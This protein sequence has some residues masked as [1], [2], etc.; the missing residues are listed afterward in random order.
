MQVRLL[1][2]AQADVRAEKIF[3]RAIE[4]ELAHRFVAALE[5]A[6]QALAAQPLAMQVLDLEIRRWPVPG[7]PHGLLYR[8][9]TTEVLVLAVFHPKQSPER[10]K[11]RSR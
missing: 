8:V 3:Y 10:W 11:T 6:V 4:P 7:F 5:Y 9:T 2:A 1:R